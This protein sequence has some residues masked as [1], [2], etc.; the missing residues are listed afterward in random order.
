M[1][2]KSREEV[3]PECMFAFL[4]LCGWWS[5]RCPFHAS[6]PEGYHGLYGAYPFT[7]SY[8]RDVRELSYMMAR[9]TR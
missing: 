4:N 7:G 6:Y 1:N 9:C 2:I 8:A 5:Y 3:S